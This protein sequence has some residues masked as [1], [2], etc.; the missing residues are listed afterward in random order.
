LRTQELWMLAHGIQIVRRQH[1]R[2]GAGR[3]AKGVTTA[4]SIKSR[5][6]ERQA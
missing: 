5:A 4:P 1:P 3:R 6:A 2:R